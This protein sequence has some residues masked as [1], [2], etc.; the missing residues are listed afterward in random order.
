MIEWRK[1]SREI[2]QSDHFDI[3]EVTSLLEACRAVLKYDTFQRAA[4]AIF[5]E[6]CKITGAAAGYVALLSSDGS[7]NEVL[8]LESGGM[9][10]SVNPDLPMPIRGL[11]SEAYRTGSAVFDNSFS[12]SDWARFMPDGHVE[13]S[14]VLF[15]PLNLEGKTRGI[16]G[17]ANKKGDFTDRD[18]RMAMAF[19]ELAAIA[20]SNSRT[21]DQLNKTVFDLGKALAEV[22]TLKGI[23]PICAQCKKIRNDRG[24]WEMVELY[25]SKHSDAEFSHSYCPECADELMR[26]LDSYST[27]GPD[28]EGEGGT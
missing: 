5:D 6:A 19:G 9:P 12:S 11:R 10:C 25:I 20:L 28:D 15:A 23:I 27:A 21:M 24:Y 13:L 18:A 22:K 2:V 14:N 1:G 7:E 8:F 4:R 3:D 16:M 17:L 26:H